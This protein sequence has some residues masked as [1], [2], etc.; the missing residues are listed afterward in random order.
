MD[1]LLFVF[2]GTLAFFVF[3]CQMSIG[4]QLLKEKSPSQFKNPY[5]E[6]NKKLIKPVK[7]ATNS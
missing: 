7:T 2:L 5:Y 6:P 3:A 4:Y 1:N